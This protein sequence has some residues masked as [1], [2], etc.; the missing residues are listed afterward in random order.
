M[1]GGDAV[2][3]FEDHLAVDMVFKRGKLLQRHNV[4]AAH[5]GHGRS[6]GRVFG[7]EKKM[8]PSVGHA[9]GKLGPGRSLAPDGRIGEAAVQGALGG[10]DRADQIHARVASTAAALEISVERA[11]GHPA[12]S[13]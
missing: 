11:H 9:L 3:H 6:L 8:P 1:I 4:G 13:R 2:A 7:G 5:N 12:G 10:R